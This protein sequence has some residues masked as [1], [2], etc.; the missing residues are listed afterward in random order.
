LLFAISKASFFRF[1]N[2]STCALPSTSA[3]SNVA[4]SLNSSNVLHTPWSILDAVLNNA[5]SARVSFCSLSKIIDSYV[6]FGLGL[7]R[8]VGA[9]SCFLWSSSFPFFHAQTLF[10]NLDQFMGIRWHISD[11][12]ALAKLSEMYCS[13]RLAA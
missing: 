9:F 10:A 7:N 2:Q 4:L 6:S 1:I 8:T 12:S 3:A 11:T 13:G 5:S